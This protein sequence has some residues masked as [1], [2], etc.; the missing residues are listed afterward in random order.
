MVS[1]VRPVNA[2]LASWRGEMISTVSSRL[3]YSNNAWVIVHP[4]TFAVQV[5]SLSPSQKPTVSPYHW[6]VFWT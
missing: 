4:W 2:P 5:I 3:L 6:G 1:I